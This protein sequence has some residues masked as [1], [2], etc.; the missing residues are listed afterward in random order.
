MPILTYC[1]ACVSG[2]LR[3][4]ISSCV[5]ASEEIP[6]VS[7]ATA[8]HT[9]TCTQFIELLQHWS[10]EDPLFIELLEQTWSYSAL[11]WCVDTSEVMHLAA[12]LELPL[13]HILMSVS[14]TYQ[15]ITLTSVCRRCC[16][17]AHMGSR[18]IL[19]APDR[20]YPTNT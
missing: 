19:K 15:C 2:K 13:Y 3:G 6:G 11:P 1:P 17:H 18:T 10:W 14:Y 20:S 12:S 7:S 4:T 8:S 9:H 16:T 5:A